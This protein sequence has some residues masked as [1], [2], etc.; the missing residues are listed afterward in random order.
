MPILTATRFKGELKQF[1]DKYKY[2]LDLT[3]E[4]DSC[5][6]D[7]D[8]ALIHK[9]TLWKTNRY[10]ILNSELLAKINKLSKLKPCEH[11]KSKNVLWQL[12]EQKGVDLP[13]ASTLLRFRNPDVFQIIDKRAYRA[14]MGVKYPFYTKTKTKR[15]ID[16][17]FSY[18]DELHKLCK[19]RGQDF[20]DIDRIL[21][22]FDKEKN[23]K[24]YVKKR[25]KN[26]NTKISTPS[27]R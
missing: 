5:K 11:E 9:I 10:Y 24:L 12:L 14:L 16:G 25:Q 15:K 4:L 19:E 22:Q 21:Y 3:K 26:K 23:G 27:E 8:M 6:D 2:N 20:K 1:L 13:M 17:Y 18:L 7:F